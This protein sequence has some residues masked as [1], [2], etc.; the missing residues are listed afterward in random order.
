MDIGDSGAVEEQ[1]RGQAQPEPPLQFAANPDRADRI[2]SEFVQRRR[3]GN[4]VRRMARFRGDQPGQQRERAIGCRRGRCRP[5]RGRVAC[6]DRVAR[7]CGRFRDDAINRQMRAVPDARHRGGQ[8]RAG[9]LRASGCSRRSERDGARPHP[10]QHAGV[11]PRSPVDH[12]GRQ[13]ERSTVRGQPLQPR[14]RDRIRNLARRFD[15]RR[16]R[17]EIHD[18]PD[19]RLPA[20]VVVEHRRPAQLG[21]ENG[22]ELR[23]VGVQD[24]PVGGRAGQVKMPSSAPAWAVSHAPS[25]SAAARSA[26]SS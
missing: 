24:V 17:R 25:T 11:R 13:A 2:G 6:R 20:R 9:G 26:T 8:C 19:R 23:R 21:A 3:P 15:Q 22:V 10:L 14:V 18:E 4:L 5:D 1:A 16:Q 7:S 12:D